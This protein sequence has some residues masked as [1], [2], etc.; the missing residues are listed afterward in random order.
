MQCKYCHPSRKSLRFR[1]WNAVRLVIKYTNKN[2]KSSGIPD[3]NFK[4]FSVIYLKLENMFDICRDQL[5]IHAVIDNMHLGL[6]TVTHI[7]RCTPTHPSTHTSVARHL[8]LSAWHKLIVTWSW[9]VDDKSRPTVLFLAPNTMGDKSGGDWVEEGGT[10]SG[11]IGHTECYIQRT[12][13]L[14]HYCRGC[15]N[16]KSANLG[17]NWLLPV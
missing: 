8:C 5:S 9:S 4:I 3:L 16:E 13:H 2:I 6:N 17:F 14:T 1:Y 15:K 12:S 7:S 11:D 10:V